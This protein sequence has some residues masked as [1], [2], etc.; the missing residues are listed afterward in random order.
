MT[1]IQKYLAF[2]KKELGRGAYGVVYKAKEKNVDGPWRAIKKIPK[3]M[4]KQP[5]LLLNEIDILKSLDHPTIVRLY[6]CFEDDKNLFLV[7][8]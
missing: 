6:E 2:Y 7:T 1:S 5:E 4:I 3:K 8:E